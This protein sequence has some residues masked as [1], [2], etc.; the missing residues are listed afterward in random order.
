MLIILL[1]LYLVT[2]WASVSLWKALIDSNVAKFE[3]DH[4][5]MGAVLFIPILLLVNWLMAMSRWFI[6]D[7]Y[8]FW[9]GLKEL[10]WAMVPV[11]N[12]FYIWD[13]WAL[14]GYAVYFELLGF[15]AN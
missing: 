8:S 13:W 1:A 7:H 11:L 12:F 9:A 3:E 5:A 10:V 4:F 14:A 15:G 6:V 2:A